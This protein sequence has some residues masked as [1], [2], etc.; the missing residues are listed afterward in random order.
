MEILK[1][2][3]TWL[4][5]GLFIGIGLTVAMYGVG[6]LMMGFYTDTA[7]SNVKTEITEGEIVSSTSSSISFEDRYKEFSSEAGLVITSHEERK[8]KNSVDILGVIENK[9]VDTWT[10]VNI[11]VELF[12]EN[13]KFVDECSEYMSGKIKPGDKKNFKVSCRRCDKNPLPEYNKYTIVVN[14]A[15]FQRK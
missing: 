5:M 14:S 7:K 3:G 1:K 8:V 2:L 4:V 12:D 13:G 6:S 9:G 15:H 10:G 11:E